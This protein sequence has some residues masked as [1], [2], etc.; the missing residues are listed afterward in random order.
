MFNKWYE[1]LLEWLSQRGLVLVAVM[2]IVAASS[3]VLLTE[4]LVQAGGR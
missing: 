1:S 4:L 2:W 3:C